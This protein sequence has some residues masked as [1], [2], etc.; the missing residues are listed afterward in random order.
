MNRKMKLLTLTLA[1]LLI[2]SSMLSVASALTY[3]VG[4]TQQG[5][6][7]NTGKTATARASGT[8]DKYV[9][10]SLTN[11]YFEINF[12]GC[13]VKRAVYGSGSGMGVA[14]ASA[15]APSSDCAGGSASATIGG[16]YLAVQGPF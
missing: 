7:L 6:M 12:A 5:L 9:T 14:N 13:L 4:N 11:R 16:A 3:A 8:Q 10:V 2:M 15:T 1:V